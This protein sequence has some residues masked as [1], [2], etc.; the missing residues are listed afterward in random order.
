MQYLT[1]AID[2]ISNEQD[3]PAFI[4]NDAGINV[5]RL[6][7]IS[8]DGWRGYYSISP[9]KTNGWTIVK[10]DWQTGD[11]SDA[12]EHAESVVNEQLEAYAA[13]RES[14]G[15]ELAVVYAPT[16]NIFSTSYA[17]LERKLDQKE[18]A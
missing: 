13:K 14:Q 9:V 6:K 8:T 15:Y 5:A 17:L 16:S 12:G 10:D 4:K 18:A 1:Q 3:I 11:W 7:Y 2:A